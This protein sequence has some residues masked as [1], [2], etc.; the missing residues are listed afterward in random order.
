[1]HSTFALMFLIHNLYV[2]VGRLELPLGKKDLD[3]VEQE[4]RTVML[5]THFLK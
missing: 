4:F 5:Q 2:L 3:A 1:M